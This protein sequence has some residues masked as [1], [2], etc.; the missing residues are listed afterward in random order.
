MSK[1]KSTSTRINTK[2]VV[3]PVFVQASDDPQHP[4]ELRI[5][6]Q[7]R[8]RIGYRAGSPRWANLS[9][10]QA[11]ALAHSLLAI[12]EAPEEDAE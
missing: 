10:S 7:S 1:S 6:L 8:K 3:D 11:R 5:G 2:T 12:A 4:I 9:R